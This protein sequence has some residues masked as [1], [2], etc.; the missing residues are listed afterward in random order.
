[1]LRA[2]EFWVE[3]VGVSRQG[4]TVRRHL[5]QPREGLRVLKHKRK[6]RSVVATERLWGDLLR[7]RFYGEYFIKLDRRFATWGV[8]D[9]RGFDVASSGN[10]RGLL[11]FG[12]QS[13]RTHFG[14]GGEGVEGRAEMNSLV[15]KY[16]A[17]LV[18]SAAIFIA[19]YQYAAAFYGEEIANVKL[20]A[21][22]VRA[23]DGR[24]AYEK[25]VAAQNALDASR[26]DAVRLSDDLDRVQRAY[27][28]RERRASADACRVE[29]AA[30][31]RCEGLLRE[32]TELLAEG[33]E[34]LQGNAAVHDARSTMS[35]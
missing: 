11:W 4:C 7:Q 23:N 16:V 28:N 20:Q 12:N 14:E 13:Y 34:L 31:A 6:S 22:I 2:R 19:G 32:S 17:V 5:L 29:R 30:I 25:L 3:A 26:R 9:D 10:L 18:A 21:A 8:D 27:Q 33:S 1:M 15:L 24:K 35:K